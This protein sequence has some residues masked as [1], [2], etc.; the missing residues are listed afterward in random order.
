MEFTR[1]HTSYKPPTYCSRTCAN[2]AP[3]RMTEGVKRKISKS[4]SAESNPNWSGG[5]W[6]SNEGRVFVRVPTNERYLHPTIRKDGYIQRYQYVW[7]T[8]HPED[9]VREGDV[10][11]HINED[12][13]DDRIENLE[14]TTQSK[15]AREHGT[16]RAHTAESRALM[17]RAQRERRARE[18]EERST[19]CG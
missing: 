9:P 8:N 15:H 13:A 1:I 7:N 16:G 19:D 14:K 5:A 11:H 12:P 6:V 10:I 17:S 4:V 3:G 18:R 2:K